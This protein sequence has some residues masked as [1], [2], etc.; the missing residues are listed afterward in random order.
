MNLSDIATLNIKS[1]YYIRS[2]ENNAISLMQNADLT[3]KP[4]I[5]KHKKFL[6][7][8]KM[9]NVVLTFGDIAIEKSKF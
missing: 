5:I 1:A 7:Y 8:I 2:S 3:K 6:P 4:N 9:G